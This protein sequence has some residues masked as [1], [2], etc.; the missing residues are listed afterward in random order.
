MKRNQ[1]YRGYWRNFTI[2]TCIV[3]C[4]VGFFSVISDDL[5]VLRDDATTFDFIISYLAIIINSLP[6]WFI[7]A[8]LVGYIFAKD[9]KSAVL[10]GAIY[11]ITAITFYFVIGY[12]YQDVPVAVPF[13]EQVVAYASWYAASTVGG[14]LGG[15]TGFF[16]RKHLMHYCL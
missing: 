6:M 3:G 4:I 13:A 15:I 2:F 11:T 5:P 12:F 14:I 1:E 7:L 9:M 8:M 16:I 10:L